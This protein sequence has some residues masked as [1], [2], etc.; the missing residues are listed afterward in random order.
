MK[1]P[2]PSRPWNPLIAQAFYQRGIIETWG[3]GTPKMAE[4]TEQAGLVA[5]EFEFVSG[6]VVVR[7]R[8]GKYVPPTRVGLNLS[9][10]QQMLLEILAQAGSATLQ[11][12]LSHVGPEAVRRTVQNNLQLLRQLGLVDSTGKRGQGASWKLRGVSPKK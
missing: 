3:R 1:R 7:F 9:P 8:P 11:Q 5:P 10:L 2:H 12:I 6:E 4:L